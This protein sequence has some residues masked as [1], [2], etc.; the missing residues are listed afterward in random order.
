MIVIDIKL[1]ATDMD[2]TL[3]NSEI[4]IS[5]ENI[6]YIKKFQENGKIFVLAS[7]RP[8][9]A[10]TNFSNELEMYK[11]NGYIL[12]YNGAEI[13]NCKTFDSIYINPLEKESIVNM[14]NYAK[15]NNIAFLTYN[16]DVIY[17]TKIDSYTMKELE[18]TK[19]KDIIQI[20]ELSEI[21]LNKVIKCMLVADNE[22]IKKHELILKNSQ[23]ADK[24]FFAI[25]LPIFLEVVNK[26]VDKGKTLKILANILKLDMNEILAI[27]DSY[28]DIPLLDVAGIK[29]ATNNAKKELKDVADYISKSNDEDALKDVIIKYNLIK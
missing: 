22:T 26:D 20:N 10:M 8:T 23:Y 2:G 4:K 5:E 28:N 21:N 12:S 6:K 25:S 29:V 27:G 7:G 9:F 17:T 18:L 14:F 1:I 16:D 11:Y 19:A 15:D 13:I 24:L 3:L